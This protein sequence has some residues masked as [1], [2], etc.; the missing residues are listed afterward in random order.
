MHLH[1]HV[2]MLSC[3]SGIYVAHRKS[4]INSSRSPNQESLRDL[5]ASLPLLLTEREPSHPFPS[6]VMRAAGNERLLLPWHAPIAH[7]RWR[8]DTGVSGV[9]WCPDR[10]I[11]IFCLI[12]NIS[13]ILRSVIWLCDIQLAFKLGHKWTLLS[14]STQRSLLPDPLPRTAWQE[15]RSSPETKWSQRL[16]S[17]PFPVSQP[18]LVCDSAVVLP[19]QSL[20]PA[21][22]P[23]VLQNMPSPAEGPFSL[24]GTSNYVPIIFSLGLFPG[25]LSTAAPAP[26]P[27]TP[28]GG[29]IQRRCSEGGP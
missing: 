11:A 4:D 9:T 7:G 27:R 8:A 5:G 21:L 13:Y 22:P 24:T 26:P 1:K 18:C 23:L 16:P 17:F 14:W 10:T 20:H 2:S 29:F 15:G 25:T 19:V 12:T 6:P 28:N 3:S